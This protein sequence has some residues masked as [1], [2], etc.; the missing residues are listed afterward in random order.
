MTKKVSV[1]VRFMNGERWNEDL[2]FHETQDTSLMISYLLKA[3]KKCPRQL[4]PIK[5]GVALF[6][7]VAEKNHQLSFFENEKKSAFF[8][9]VDKINDKYGKN[10]LHLASLHEHL[11]AAPTHIAFSRIPELDELED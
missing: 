2:S 10:T 7:F 6:D 9:V 5:V 1:S 8:K 3:Y 4:K 11:G